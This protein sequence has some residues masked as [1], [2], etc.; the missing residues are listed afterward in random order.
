V[1]D[2]G[3]LYNAFCILGGERESRE[4]IVG[5]RVTG[6]RVATRPLPARRWAG[7]I[8]PCFLPG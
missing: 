1:S 6:G 8:G 7:E 4:C 3:K 2:V 5:G